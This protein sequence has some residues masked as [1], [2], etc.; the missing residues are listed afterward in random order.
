MSTPFTG[1]GYFRI[2]ASQDPIVTTAI[3]QNQLSDMVL[4]AKIRDAMTALYGKNC[5]LVSA[6]APG[7]V[8][9][10]AGPLVYEAISIPGYADG[11]GRLPINC[12]A[13]I[14]EMVTPPGKIGAWALDA[15]G[16]PEWKLT[17]IPV[18]APMGQ[19][20]TGSFMPGAAYTA[21]DVMNFLLKQWP[22]P[23]R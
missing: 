22:W 17:D 21:T 19:P 8:Q 23:L 7:E 15:N 18:A 11:A 14:L 20:G 6:L 12:Q 9:M 5:S 10:P 4:A 2:N 3:P 1:S 16:G 13:L